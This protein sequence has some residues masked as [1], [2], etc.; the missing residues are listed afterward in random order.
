MDFSKELERKLT[1]AEY[2]MVAY[3]IE[4]ATDLFK[5]DKDYE[6]RCALEDAVAVLQAAGEYSAAEKVRYYTR[7]C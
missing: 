4:K 1:G 6:A 2:N 7:F 3:Y 5:N